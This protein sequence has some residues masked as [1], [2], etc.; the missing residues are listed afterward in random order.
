MRKHWPGAHPQVPKSSKR[1]GM[2]EIITA[3]NV[4][5]QLWEPNGSE[6]RRAV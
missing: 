5:L 1:V 3:I 2:K 6:A 4:R